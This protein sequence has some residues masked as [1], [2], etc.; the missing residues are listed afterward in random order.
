MDIALYGSGGLL[1]QTKKLI[2]AKS[3]EYNR[4][5][6]ATAKGVSWANILISDLQLPDLDTTDYCCC[7]NH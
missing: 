5:P 7:L 6:L 4:T 3:E 1:S 2:E